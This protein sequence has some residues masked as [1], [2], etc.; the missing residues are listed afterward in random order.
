MVGEM[1]GYQDLT[2]NV[3][4]QTLELYTPA[5]KA[6]SVTSATIH[7]IEN[8]DA[9]IETSLTSLTVDS[10]STTVHSASGDGQSNPAIIN[11]SAI[12][13]VVVGRHYLVTSAHGYS[14]VVT[15]QSLPNGGSPHAC[16][17]RS[18]MH[19]AY[20]ADDTLKAIRIYGTVPSTFLQDQNNITDPS[21]RV[22]YRVRWQYVDHNSVTQV[23]M[24]SCSLV[25]YPIVN[26]VIPAHVDQRFP[27]WLDA[28]AVDYRIDQGRG[29]IDA[30]FDAVRIDLAQESLADHA[31]RDQRVLAELVIHKTAEIAAEVAVMRGSASADAVQIARDGYKERL[32]RLIRVPHVDFQ[33]ATGGASGAGPKT[34]LWKR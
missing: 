6:T 12:T 34:P 14:E 29:L 21:K 18:P 13:G 26:P 20:A 19:N 27:G 15:I 1:I 33:H 5:G 31:L 2:Y 11:L 28:L 9:T 30:A 23:A 4:G 25:R 24:T 7:E 10:V 16:V 17:V 22:G 3:T 8:D 32:Q